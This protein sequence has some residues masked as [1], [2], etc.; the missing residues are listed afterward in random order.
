MIFWYNKLH[1]VLSIFYIIMT[2]RTLVLI[3]MFSCLFGFA[4]SAHAESAELKF[5]RTL[6]QGES[7]SD[8]IMLQKVLATD[9]AVY[10]EGKVT[11][12]FGS[13]TAA[14]VKRF[15][16]KS[17]LAAVGIV[18]P[19]TLE[20]LNTLSSVA[21]HPFGASQPIKGQYIVVFKDSVGDPEAESDRMI[22]GSGGKKL[23]T[24]AHA[25]KG[26]AAT[27][28]DTAAEALKH[29]PNVAYIEQDMTVSLQSVENDATWG[30]DRIDQR[31]LPLSTTY[32]YNSTGAGV[33]A[34]VI[35]TGIRS[36]HVEFTGRLL[37]GFDAVGD[38]LG[39]SD[40][41]GHGTH[42]SGTIG[43]TTYGV[44]KGVSLIPVRVLDCS[45]NSEWSR[46]IAG[47]DWVAGSPLRPAVAN[48]SLGGAA[49]SSIDAAVAGLISKGVTVVVAA[50]N[51]NAD[52]C[53]ASPARVPSALTVGAVTSIDYRASYS[54]VGSCLDLFAPG[55]G[56]TSS[57]NTANNATNTLSGTS[58]ASPHVAGVAA[59]M[60]E[61]NPSA[62]PE[63][64]AAQIV[65]SATADR[66]QY[67]GTGSPNLLL[68]S[69]GGGSTPPPPPPP[70][71]SSQTIAVKS[72][73]KSSVKSGSGWRAS[74]TV[75]VYDVV[76]N[77]VVP[78]VTVSGSFTIGGKTS[79]VTSSTGSC[80]LTSTLIKRT[81]GTTTTLS[82][83]NLSG[84]AMVYDASRNL[85][86][87]IVITAP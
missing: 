63:T 49:T 70:P 58:M 30:L 24:Y 15:Q 81:A 76:T 33:Y 11:G 35:D 85:Q 52:A 25:I 64:I 84:V 51:N 44:A 27:L 5:V 1:K 56:V 16:A 53:T 2:R 19:Q 28:P 47:V 39:T 71:P 86:S 68:Y 14:A 3:T 31:D 65:S 66:V 41:N 67:P 8:V 21:D 38:G 46:V 45:G 69:L 57:W 7:G 60:L 50:G 34:F 40:C 29:N 78:N 37:P 42:V 79:C 83:T 48:M 82:V 87:Q 13:L 54:N 72:I 22:A 75:T 18:G 20:K 80:T 26:F 4:L 73:V 62:T 43:G 10:P 6:K 17:G 77:A 36:D 12:Y 23:H 74:G 59:L 9:P 55:H 61:T 32:A